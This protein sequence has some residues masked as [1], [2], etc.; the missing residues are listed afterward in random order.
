MEGSRVVRSQAHK[1]F[2]IID[3]QRV[4]A[5][6]A[7]KIPGS[8]FCL[9]LSRPQGLTSAGSIRPIEKSSG[10]IGA[11]THD[12]PA[13]SPRSFHHTKSHRL[14]PRKT[15]E[16]LAERGCSPRPE[17]RQADLRCVSERPHRPKENPH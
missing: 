11:L 5:L 8:R 16:C 13:C 14:E 9:R 12:L 7:Q 6:N 4:H 10:F 2:Q 3:L 17:Y 15:R 1:Y